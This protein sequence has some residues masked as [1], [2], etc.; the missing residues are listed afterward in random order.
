[1]F[2]LCFAFLLIRL[3]N[4]FVIRF[5]CKTSRHAFII[6]AAGRFQLFACNHVS[7]IFACNI[8]GFI[9]CHQAGVKSYVFK[10]IRHDFSGRGKGSVQFRK[11]KAV[12]IIIFIKANPGETPAAMIPKDY[13]HFFCGIGFNSPFQKIRKGFRLSHILF[14]GFR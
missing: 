7:C 9:I 8:C 3:Q 5:I 4:I 13:P 10:L 2:S 11:T 14:V 6:P 1:M 12:H